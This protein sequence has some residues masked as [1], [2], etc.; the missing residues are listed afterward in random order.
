ML[1]QRVRVWQ[2]RRCVSALLGTL[3]ATGA[4]AQSP[5]SCAASSACKMVTPSDPARCA[6]LEKQLIRP[7]DFVAGGQIRLDRYGPIVS[8]WMAG[9]CYRRASDGRYDWAHDATARDTGP[10]ITSFV[11]QKFSAKTFSTHQVARVWYS[12]LMYQWVAQNRPK[13]PADAPLNP[14]LI[15]DGA[16]MVKEMWPSPMAAYGAECFDC[17]APSANGAVFF[18]RDSKSFSTGWFAGY[19]GNGAQLDWPAAPSNP[20]TAMG[21]GGQGFCLNCHGSTQPGNTFASMNNISGH[22]ATFLTQLPPA[23]PAITTPSRH[24]MLATPAKRLQPLDQALSVPSASFLQTFGAPG[25]DTIAPPPNMPSQTYDSVLIPGTGPVDHFMTSTQ[26]VGCHQANATGL[27]L[28]MLDFTPGP[29]GAGGDGKPVSISPYSMWSS[30]PMGL[31]GR[32]PVFYSQLESEQIL[33]ADL[34]KNATPAQK[35]ALR[36][37]IQ[38][39][40]LQCHGNMGQRQ[41]AID[42]HA[43]T[44]TC[45]PFSRAEV[46]VVPYPSTDAGWPHQAQQSSYAA[47]ARDGVSCASCHRLALGEQAEKHADAPWNVCIQQKQKSLNPN[48]SGLAATF[49]GS[50]PLVAPEVLNGPFEKPLTQPMQNSLR[51]IPQH[52]SAIRSA[53]VCASCHTI[54]LPVLDREQPEARCG[55]QTDPA[56]PFRCFPKRYEQTTYPEWA[57]SAYRTGTLNEKPLPSGPG[58]TPM[59]CQ[60]CHMPS[61]DSNNQPL[62]SK[63]ASIEE[64]SNYPDID[65]R[66]PAAL[67]DLPQRSGYAQHQLVG[68]NFF[69]TEMAQQFPSIFGI[70]AQDPGLVGMNVAPLQVTENIIVSRVSQRTIALTVE[71]SWDASSGT[72]SAAVTVDNHA[73]HKFPSGVGFR[74]AFIE[75]QV[76]N[77][78]GKMLWGSGRSN[79][80]GVLVDESGQAL[81]GEFWWQADCSARLPNAWQPHFEEITRQDQA[82]IYQE[83][84]TDASGMLTTSFLSINAH[85]KD[86][87]L[88]PHGFLPQAERVAIAAALGDRTPLADEKAAF[89]MDENLG[90]AVGPEGEAANDPDYQN[91]SGKD[92]LRY[93]VTGL[94]DKPAMVSV[95]LYYQ[96]ISPSYQQDRYCTAAHA[97]GTPTTDTARLKYLAM[98]LDLSDTPAAGWKLKIGPRTEVAIK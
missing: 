63:I 13:V 37:V 84:V 67:I 39:T 59:T 5:A 70:R 58:A 49:T 61:V 36:S 81:K 56:D 88:Q 53:E 11:D 65:Y 25:D 95:Q 46:D 17:K 12:P 4:F 40:C 44:G 50:F 35:T 48:F 34:N 94:K 14:P 31:A 97:A 23:S 30:S 28:D 96:A 72:L 41:K 86:N 27:Q 60:Q 6:V 90:V 38:D 18:I 33:H 42:S 8:E 93:V 57:F 74:R 78:A 68:L 82:Q 91:G 83:L 29:L 45:A 26:C 55:P 75:F 47:L 9:Y 87:R 51:V 22:P 21:D 66:L 69:L 16:I 7:A 73:G 62:V 80:Q 43:Q 19:W 54:H 76:L 92:Q 10:F 24:Q 98:H 15:P 1:K 71:P 20:L 2:M 77:V 32:D 79:D 64:Y 85:P 89:A 52:S 3:M